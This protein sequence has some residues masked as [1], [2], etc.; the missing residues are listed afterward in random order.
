VR[1]FKKPLL[2]AKPQIIEPEIRRGIERWENEG[3]RLYPRVK[4]NQQQT[5]MSRNRAISLAGRLKDSG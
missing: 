5:S 2:K 1:S 3:G 4:K